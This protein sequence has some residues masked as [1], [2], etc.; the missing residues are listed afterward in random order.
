MKDKLTEWYQNES[1]LLTCRDMLTD[2]ESHY[3]WLKNV[4]NT[5]ETNPDY[6]LTQKDIEFLEG[7]IRELKA[8]I[9][10]L[11][12]WFEKHPEPPEDSEHDDRR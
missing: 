8:E 11:E 3:F 4:T 5:P 7:E 2:H 10:R 1:T 12:A 6:E 9:E